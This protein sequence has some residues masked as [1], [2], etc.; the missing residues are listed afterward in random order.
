MGV[1]I[2]NVGLPQFGSAA[3]MTAGRLAVTGRAQ[4]ATGK[5]R[6]PPKALKG[7]GPSAATT[8]ESFARVRGE[9]HALL[10]RGSRA[11]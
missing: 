10:E 8:T 11:L 9:G 7:T 1:R 2:P 4:T 5:N 3:A 6:T